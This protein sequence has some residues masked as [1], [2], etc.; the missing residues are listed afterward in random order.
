MK[1]KSL[2]IIFIICGFIGILV[3]IAFSI[4]ISQFIGIYNGSRNY[5]VYLNIYGIDKYLY[6]SG[7]LF[8]IGI[9]ICS[10]EIFINKNKS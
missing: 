6:I 8:L 10:V 9:I 5:L 2:G 4:S 3:L 1:K 7:F